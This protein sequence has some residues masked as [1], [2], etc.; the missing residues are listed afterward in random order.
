MLA[1]PTTRPGGGVR[2]RAG[3]PGADGY[4]EMKGFCLFFLGVYSGLVL[5][6][7]VL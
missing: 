4:L 3:R 1:H 5:D 6:M 2:H 7:L